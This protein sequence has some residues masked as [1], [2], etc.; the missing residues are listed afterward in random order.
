MLDLAPA[1]DLVAHQHV[2][3]PCPHQRLR[4]AHLLTA[5]SHRAEGRLPARDH[6]ALVGLGVR[7]NP[8]SGGGDVLRHRREIALEGVEIDE[9]SRRIDV[10]ERHCDFSRW[11]S[12]R[13]RPSI[14]KSPYRDHRRPGCE[15]ASRAAGVSTAPP[16]SPGASPN[17]A[18]PCTEPRPGPAAIRTRRTLARS[19][20]PDGPHR[21]SCAATGRAGTSSRRTPGTSR[22]SRPGTRRCR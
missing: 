16:P 3:H 15:N 4:L 2:G 8:H 11:V 13:R 20:A 21:P 19:C 17:G 6:R 10:G 14:V 9:Q 7:A 1:H 18:G 22:P 5:H 12:H